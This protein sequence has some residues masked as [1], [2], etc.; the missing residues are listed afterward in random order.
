M[1]TGIYT[2]D[3]LLEDQIKA[4]TY[5]CVK[6]NLISQYNYCID[7]NHCICNECYKQTKKMSN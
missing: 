5:E 4:K 3:F 6:C 1:K 2:S 7:C